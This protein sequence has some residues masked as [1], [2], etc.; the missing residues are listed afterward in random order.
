MAKPPKFPMLTRDTRVLFLPICPKCENTVLRPRQLQHLIFKCTARTSTLLAV[1]KK[2]CYYENIFQN[3]PTNLHDFLAID[4]ETEKT[5]DQGYIQMDLYSGQERAFGIFSYSGTANLLL[6]HLQ[7]QNQVF[8]L[9]FLQK[10]KLSVYTK[11]EAQ[12]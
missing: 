4:D 6:K 7:L 1:P 12:S 10:K 9:F 2:K 5:F 3:K 8:P 11:T